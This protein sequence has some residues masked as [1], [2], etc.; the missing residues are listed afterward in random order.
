MTTMA[1]TR[2]AAHLADLDSERALLGAA[3]IWD[4]AIA[5]ALPIVTADDLHHPAHQHI[6]QAIVTARQH[7]PVDAVI[8]AERIR[9]I[10]HP[11]C[12]MEYLA[13][14]QAAAPSISNTARVAR[15]IAD[16]AARRRLVHASADIADLAAN[17][18]TAE[19][20]IDRARSLVDRIT[21]PTVIG[22]P[23]FD[24]RQLMDLV[25]MTYDWLIP[26][27]LERGDRLLLTAGEGAGKSTL[28]AQLAV[29]AACG[30]H[31][32]WW[33]KRHD[34][35]NVLVVDC[36]NGDKRVMRRYTAL[37]RIA[38]DDLEDGRLRI[39]WRP[40][41]LDLL[42]RTD[43]SWLLDRCLANQAD[44][45]VI[46]P[47]YKLYTGIRPGDIGGEETTKEVT[48]ALDEIRT[49]AGV[50]LLMETHAPHGNGTGRDLRPAGSSVWLRWPEF[51]YGLHAQTKDKV[52]FDWD[53]WRGPRDDR[54]WPEMLRRGAIREGHRW[55]W[56]PVMPTTQGQVGE[57]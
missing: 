53:A 38:G 26:G 41:G 5:D 52:L 10:D 15:T 37:E 25:D 54:Q 39:E 33:T 18:A 55:P 11:D 19:D 49:R 46:G 9:G 43:R 14:L 1:D 48:G 20:A 40:D 12:T 47:V 34:P 17:A 56:L 13:G 6:W 2:T 28:L 44:I 42:G 4:Q 27:V 45:L 29:Q 32:W 23:S 36:E 51:G 16:L 50:A 30:I 57:F 7:G 35:L 21:L 22:A 8:V 31:P 3:L 24:V